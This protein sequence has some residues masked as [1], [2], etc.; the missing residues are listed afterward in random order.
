MNARIEIDCRKCAN[1]EN[2]SCRLY[3]KNANIAVEKCAKNGFK[4]YWK[5]EAAENDEQSGAFEE[6]KSPCRSGR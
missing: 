1:C 4:G 6:N 2:N 5:K 3:G